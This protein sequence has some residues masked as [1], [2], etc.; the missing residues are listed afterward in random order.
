MNTTGCV[1]IATDTTPNVYTNGSELTSSGIPIVTT[2]ENTT[3]YDFTWSYVDP[4]VYE[5]TSSQDLPLDKT[6]FSTGNNI[7]IDGVWSLLMFNRHSITSA[8]LRV[9]GDGT[10]MNGLLDNTNIEIKIYN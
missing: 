2:L 5:C 1:F 9:I 4:G 6:I 8:L 3:G 7:S 10:L